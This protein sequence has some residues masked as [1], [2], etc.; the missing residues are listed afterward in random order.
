M[1]NNGF[2]KTFIETETLMDLCLKK[3]YEYKQIKR[4]NRINKNGVNVVDKV[5][6]LDFK[7]KFSN[8]IMRPYT[9]A[10]VTISVNGLM[11]TGISFIIDFQM[12]NDNNVRSFPVYIIK[13]SLFEKFLGL[14]NGHIYQYK[15]LCERLYNGDTI[16]DMK[17]R[18]EFLN[19]EILHHLLEYC[20]ELLGINFLK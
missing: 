20:R 11:Y 19:M 13:T 10:K 2:M 17:Y 5:F 9:S 1:K 7:N 12:D 4:I 16:D 3:L 18:V 15:L 8:K 14:F 6:H